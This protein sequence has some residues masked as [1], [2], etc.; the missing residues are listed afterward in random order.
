M[1]AFSSLYMVIRYRYIYTYVCVCV[2]FAIDTI[3]QFVPGLT[4]Q[5]CLYK[6]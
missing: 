1:N 2:F 5:N 3:E 6:K 4:E